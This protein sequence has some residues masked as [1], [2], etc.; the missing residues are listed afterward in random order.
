METHTAMNAFRPVAWYA[1]DAQR[2][3]SWIQRLSAEEVA[4]FD[5]ALAHASAAGKPML[6]MTQADFPLSAA[7]RS[8]LDRAIDATQGRWG[9]C[10]LKGFP[11]DRWSEDET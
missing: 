5:A 8:A 11:V 9:M 1:E 4:G 6:D 7:A 10:L 2:E 3:P